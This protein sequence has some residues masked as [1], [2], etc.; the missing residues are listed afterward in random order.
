M[1]LR[2]AYLTID[3][4]PSPNTEKVLTYL[5]NHNIQALFFCIGQ[6]LETHQNIMIEAIQAGHHLANHSY[7][8]KRFSTLSFEEGC[9]EIE[10]T[11]RLIE[12][13]YKKA[14]QPQIGKYFRFPHMDRGTAGWIVDYKNIDKIYR[15]DVIA[16]FADGLYINLDPPTEN[17]IE[18][19]NRLQNFLKTEGYLQPFKNVDHPWFQGTELETARDCMY[20]YSNSDWMLLDRHRGRWPYKTLEDLKAK[21]DHDTYLKSQ[22]STHIILAHDKPEEELFPAFKTTIDHMLENGIEFLQL[23]ENPSI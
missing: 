18:Q 6:H 22:Q 19:K 10:K 8:H 16:L 2:K 11:E 23:N 13:C 7:T 12:K 3:D 21:I 1:P 4:S 17:M 5:E 14:R 20:T 15:E 9:K